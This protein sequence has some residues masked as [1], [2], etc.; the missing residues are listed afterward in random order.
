MIPLSKIRDMSEE[1]KKILLPFSLTDIINP[2]DNFR[3]E[4]IFC[5]E[6]TGKLKNFDKPIVK[7]EYASK[8]KV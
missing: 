5:S 7:I 3:P 8:T 4:S 6:H 1:E 2:C